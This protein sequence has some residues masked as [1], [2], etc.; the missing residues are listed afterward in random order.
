M[1]QRVN[2]LMLLLQWLRL[3]LWVPS[4]AWELPH[5]VGAAKKEKGGVNF[6]LCIFF[7]FTTI[8]KEV[9]LSKDG[10]KKILLC[11]GSLLQRLY[12]VIHSFNKY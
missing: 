1:E 12:S 4:L 5:A 8:K 2:D 7:F 6:M 11:L 9:Y 10:L 3:L